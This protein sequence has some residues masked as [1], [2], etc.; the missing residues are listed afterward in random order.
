[1]DVTTTHKNLSFQRTPLQDVANM[2][3]IP[4]VGPVYGEKLK[5]SNIDIPVKLMGH[6]MV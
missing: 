4:D 6:F 5:K 1:M 3:D 2:T